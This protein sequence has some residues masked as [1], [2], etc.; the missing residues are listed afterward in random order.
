[1][2]KKKIINDPVHGFLS[3]HNELI[4]DIINHPDFQRLRRI[5]QLGLTELVYPGAIH[6]RFHH[7]LGAMHLMSLALQSLRGKGIEITEEEYEGALL[8]ILLHDIGHGPFSHALE[9]TILADVPHEKISLLLIQKLNQEFNGALDLALQ[10][11]NNS[12]PR[13]FLH[14]LV[15]SQLDMDRM[16]YLQRDCFFTGV[17]EGTIGADRIIKMLNVKDDNIVVEE[18]GIY[19][20]ENF[21]SARRLMYWQVYLHKTTVSTE[22]MLIQLIRRA[23][24]L[25][26]GGE[27][28]TGKLN[29]K[30]NQSDVFASPALKIFL[31]NRIDMEL[32]AA[33]A[34]YMEAFASLDD[35]DI[36]ACIKI[37]SQHPDMV[38]SL[39]SK[40]L[41]HRRL[42]KSRL[43][44]DK[45]PFSKMKS[46]YKK[47]SEQTGLKAADVRYLVAY[48]EVSNAAYVAV[49]EGIKILKKNGEIVDVAQA[50]DLP[51]IKALSKIVRKYYLCYPKNISL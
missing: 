25:S 44:N 24:Y 40:M 7:A 22:Q 21:L 13:R 51:N 17:S 15:S 5:R 49:G 39:L 8:A 9:T 18:K 20:I 26:S 38:L 47:I 29:L 11:F 30:E 46:V 42:F 35:S 14:Q 10:I 6:T 4:F 23:R 41:L 45:V 2:N 34:E 48:G 16:D 27:P 3:I 43:E 50:S 28:A 37:W 1:M 33:K 12:Y 19:S 32:F 36:W 31:T